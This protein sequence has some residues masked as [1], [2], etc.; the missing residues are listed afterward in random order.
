MWEKL[1][2]IVKC[3]SPWA[4]PI[5]I[6]PKSN[7]KLRLCVDF[8]YLNSLSIP[9]NWPLPN[10]DELLSILCDMKVCS[11]LDARYGFLNIFIKPK[12][13]DKT[14]FVCHLGQYKFLRMPFGLRN[15]P[16][17]FQRAIEHILSPVLNKYVLVYM[18]DVIVFSPNIE[19]H[20]IHLAKVF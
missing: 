2:Y 17:S 4:S 1:G 12:D 13:I 20:F 19:L 16:A 11:K 6:V 15:A 10:I 8:R 14:S 18:D 7:G 3:M 5:V 9:Y